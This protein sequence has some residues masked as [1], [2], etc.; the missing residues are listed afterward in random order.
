MQELTVRQEREAETESKIVEQATT[1]VLLNYAARIQAV[2][3]RLRLIRDA[4]TVPLLG[5]SKIL[6]NKAAEDSVRGC[7]DTVISDLC[8]DLLA[9]A[10]SAVN[11][12]DTHD[13]LRNSEFAIAEVRAGVLAKLREYA[14]KCD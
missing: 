2:E 12:R 14:N 4:I 8:E 11:T 9:D 6:A 10:T 7:E 13:T 5:N 1:D 3:N